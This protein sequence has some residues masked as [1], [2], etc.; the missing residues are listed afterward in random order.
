MP[1]TTPSK[2]PSEGKSDEPSLLPTGIPTELTRSPSVPSYSPSRF[3][4]KPPSST[5][6][7]LPSNAP[8]KT[9]ILMPT[10]YP[11]KSLANSNTIS[12][13]PG[14]SNSPTPPFLSDFE[15]YTPGRVPEPY[16]QS[17]QQPP[18]YLLGFPENKQ[19]TAV[20]IYLSTFESFNR[21]VN[22]VDSDTSAPSLATV[23]G[24]E[25][26]PRVGQSR[27]SGGVSSDSLADKAMSQAAQQ[28]VSTA[29]TDESTKDSQKKAISEGSL[30]TGPLQKQ[31]P[32]VVNMDWVKWGSMAI[33]TVC[34]LLLALWRAREMV[35]A[36]ACVNQD[37][38]AVM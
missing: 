16:L 23:Q 35:A 27:V 24:S 15:V 13:S 1:T 37:S 36:Y 17:I 38:N 8:S 2:V 25:R 9:D 34:F 4:T 33:A 7:L 31:S 6:T 11:S 19:P 18:S 26:L 29:E 32:W 3:P 28:F 22:V 20:P 21:V 30:A 10:L 12:P 5:S 14:S